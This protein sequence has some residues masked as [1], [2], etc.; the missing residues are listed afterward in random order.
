[1]IWSFLKILIFIALVSGVTLGATW[2]ADTGAGLR[3]SV[4]TVEFVL[5]PV[6]AVI[7]VLVLL[8]AM[9]LLLK[10]AGL[11]SAVV[12]F[13][14]G[15]ET[16]ISRYFDRNRERKGFRAL[17]DALVAIASGDGRAALSHARKADK[18]L[19][20]P[21]L[22][23]LVVAQ[24]AEVAQDPRQAAEAYK[25]LLSNDRTR[26]VGIR[27]LMR[28]K[29]AEGDTEA[30]LKLA[31]KAFS[32]NPRQEDVQD[33][34]L[35]LQTQKG[36]WKG[37]RKVLG[38][39]LRHGQLPRDV[40]NRRDAVLAL[41]EAKEVFSEDAPIEAREAAIEANR[42]SPDLVPAAVMAAEAYLQQG[43]PKY[44]ERIL[45][46]A[47]AAQ[48]HP[49]LAAAYARIV[50]DETP[51]ARLKRFEKLLSAA[52]DHEETRLL[53]A[54]LLI[55]AEDFPAARRALGDL[56]ETH[57]T[58]RSLTLMAAIARGLGEDEA[59]VRGW[60]TRAL[61]A[62]RGPQWICDKCNTVHAEWAPVCSNCGGFDTL[63]WREAPGEPV[64]IPNE[65]AMLPL[66]VGSRGTESDKQ[67]GAD[68]DPAEDVLV[69]GEDLGQK[70]EN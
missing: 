48:P 38:E 9:W 62:S 42:R 59:L 40:Y 12:R 18:Y 37:A 3:I 2:L 60:L 32:M 53:R 57:P 19:Q 43:K 36:D 39:K 6:Q 1:M 56:A 45:R 26:F 50:P 54:E 21:E 55:A 65:T 34:L 8:L 27:G 63:S 23:D 66:I 13:L 10:L 28:Q 16:A 22:T 68:T 70:P 47:W 7:L 14:N 69:L 58:A 41:Q 11:V 64:T 30:A 5:G 35:R 31:E 67:D 20:K 61:T 46:K 52:P 33:T 29:L 24:A 15:D 51:E 44:A 49:D 17:S 25:R 4:G